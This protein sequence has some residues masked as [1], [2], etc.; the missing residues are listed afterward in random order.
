MMHR[1]VGVGGAK[2]LTEG[3]PSVLPNAIFGLIKP[4]YL[5]PA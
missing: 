4:N 5:Y 2:P 3:L 1:I